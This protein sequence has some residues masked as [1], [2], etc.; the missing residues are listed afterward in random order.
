MS[1]TVLV[2]LPT[3]TSA[4]SLV[5]VARRRPAMGGV[6]VNAIVAVASVLTHV[7]LYLAL[8]SDRPPRAP[9]HRPTL[10][11]IDVAPP[12]RVPAVP[13][14][15]PAPRLVPP[16]AVP[17]RIARAHLA[18]PPASRARPAPAPASVPAP[19]D[20]VPVADLTGVTL[21]NDG[22]AAGWSSAVGNGGAMVGPIGRAGHAGPAAPTNS[23]PAPA[24]ASMVPLADLR[25]RPAPPDLDA[26]LEHNYPEQ[27]RR[28]GL[29]GSAVVRARILPSGAIA[30]IQPLSAS[31][32]A[33][34]DA[35][36]RTLAG[37]R[38]S[39]PIDAVGHPCT[40]EIRYI[41]RFELRQ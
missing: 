33:F 19:P 18:E 20:P 36:R 26:A 34:A 32:P 38:W 12:P 40:T 31:A 11:T 9:V 15:P 8:R 22:T 21:T 25:R 3:G 1:P 29:T 4:R 14:P 2:P 37:S 17:V 30:T 13:P 23:P 6:T 27:A 7:A 41:C 16:A 10:V 24:G 5:T 39:P 28:E 35:C